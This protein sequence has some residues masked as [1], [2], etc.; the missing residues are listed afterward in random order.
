MTG[1][2]RGCR[3]Y[4]PMGFLRLFNQ[5]FPFFLK[6]RVLRYVMNVSK[7]TYR[8]SGLPAI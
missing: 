7:F 1:H 6:L 4:R 2:F 5:T 3:S 8:P